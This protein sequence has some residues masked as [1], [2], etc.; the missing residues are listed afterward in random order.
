ME[1]IDCSFE[2]ET[3]SEEIVLLGSGMTI[4][5]VVI[6][7]DWVVSVVLRNDWGGELLHVC[8]A[9]CLA[10]VGFRFRKLLS[11]LCL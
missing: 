8:E 6:W 3:C 5:L 2:C 7:L 9:Q 1:R 11:S 10:S 4:L